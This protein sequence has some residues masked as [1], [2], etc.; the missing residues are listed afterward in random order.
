MGIVQIKPII[1]QPIFIPDFISFLFGILGLTDTISHIEV[2]A[3]CNHNGVRIFHSRILTAYI[4]GFG[5]TSCKGG[6]QDE[7]DYNK[8]DGFKKFAVLH[9]HTPIKTSNNLIV[10]LYTDTRKITS[11]FG[12]T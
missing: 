12:N 8:A 11:F 2:I 1:S 5:F 4:M 3:S 6:T 7:N 9:K 10:K